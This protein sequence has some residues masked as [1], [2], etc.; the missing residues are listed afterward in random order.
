LAA[1]RPVVNQDTGFDTHLPIG[2]GLFA[3]RTPTDAV[4][5]FAT[6]AAD[7]PRHCRAARALAVEHFAPGRVLAALV[8]AAR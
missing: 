3:F 4:A 2:E 5:A 7:Y 1:G 6:I 8:G